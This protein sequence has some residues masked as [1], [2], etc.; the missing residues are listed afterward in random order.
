MVLR[1]SGTLLL[2]SQAFLGFILLAIL[3]YA[4]VQAIG[5]QGFADISAVEQYPVVGLETHL[6]GDVT[7][8]ITLNI[9]RRLAL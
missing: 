4:A 2:Y 9:V 3:L 6:G 8:Q 1:E 7:G 5:T